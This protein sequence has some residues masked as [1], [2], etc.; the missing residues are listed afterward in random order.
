MPPPLPR[1]QNEEKAVEA[2]AWVEWRGVRNPCPPYF[3]A[4]RDCPSHKRLQPG[5][6]IT[7]QQFRRHPMPRVDKTCFCLNKARKTAPFLEL[8]E[9]KQLRTP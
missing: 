2:A 3:G 7:T 5:L 6:T 4:Q 9:G 8:N 1:E